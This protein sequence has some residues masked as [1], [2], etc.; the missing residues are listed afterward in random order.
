M[1]RSLAR[2]H[3]MLF[4]ECSAKTKVGIQQAFEELVLKVLFLF[5]NFCFAL[6][7]RLTVSLRQHEAKTTR[8][9]G[10]RWVYLLLNRG[11]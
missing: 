11:K 8:A 1:G 3:Q 2:D 7:P 5:A 10:E 9:T 4:I 6:D